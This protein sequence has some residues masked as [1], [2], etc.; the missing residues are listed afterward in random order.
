MLRLINNPEP[1]AAVFSAS[2]RSTVRQLPAPAKFGSESM[3]VKTPMP[4]EA[5][6]NG[7]KRA[8]RARPRLFPPTSITTRA[9]CEFDALLAIHA[10]FQ[11]LDDPRFGSVR[12]LHFD[13]Q[14]GSI[15]MQRVIATELKYLLARRWIGSLVGRQL[16]AEIF[17]NTGAWL[18][19]FHQM[20]WPPHAR[21]RFA[22][23]DEWVASIEELAEFLIEQ[24]GE[25]IFLRALAQ[26]A[27]ELARRFL[28]PTLPTALAH[29]DFAPRNILVGPVERITVLDTPARWWA[30]TYMDVAYFLV[31]IKASRAQIYSQA[32]AF[33]QHDLMDWECHFLAGYFG[34]SIPWSAVRL[35]ELQTAMDRWAALAERG[36]EGSMPRT[37]AGRMWYACRAPWMARFFRGYLQSVLHQ[38][39]QQ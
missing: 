8:S 32:W 35:F 14:T 27:G 10:H 20:K 34:K 29:S 38:M 31:G 16:P 23:R 30:P 11:K 28:P 21:E 37:L 25:A 3:L 36:T 12:P 26:R 9:A 22:R 19:A 15:A 18:A 5:V 6:P 4:E 17:H 24:Q 33:G 2:R 1:S 39:E 7:G 13:P